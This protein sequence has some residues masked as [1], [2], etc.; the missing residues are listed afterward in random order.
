MQKR[1]KNTG[2]AQKCLLAYNGFEETE[3]PIRRLMQ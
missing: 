1:K 2:H 3:T